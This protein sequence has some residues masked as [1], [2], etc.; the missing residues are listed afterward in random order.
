MSMNRLDWLVAIAGVLLTS[1]F[2][3]CLI[4]TELILASRMFLKLK[5][6]MNNLS[7]LVRP[8]QSP[9]V[10]TQHEMEGD[11]MGIL[12]FCGVI[13]PVEMCIIGASLSY[14]FNGVISCLISLSVG[15]VTGWLFFYLSRTIR[16]VKERFQLLCVLIEKARVETVIEDSEPGADARRV[17]E[18]RWKATECQW[19]LLESHLNAHTGDKHHIPICRTICNQETLLLDV[20]R[21][22]LRQLGYHVMTHHC[23]QGTQICLCKGGYHVCL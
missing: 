9:K 21:D 13:I 14:V 22:R 17:E 10:R 12:F 6:A 1:L 4:I 16:A 15:T 20:N 7:F 23:E 8:K 2:F 18:K 11:F 3:T 5:S 19:V